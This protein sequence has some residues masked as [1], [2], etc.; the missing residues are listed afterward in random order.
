MP[1]V[2]IFGV[3]WGIGDIVKGGC[4]L[5]KVKFTSYFH[6]DKLLKF[7]YL[8]FVNQAK[9]IKKSTYRTICIYVLC[10]CIKMLKLFK[11]SCYK[12][13]W[14]IFACT[15]CT[16]FIDDLLSTTC[17]LSIHYVKLE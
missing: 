9:G 5:C 12:I 7:V 1:N 2:L 6:E 14:N 15:F 13:K 11:L 10:T 16:V 3:G 4:V 8:R 17:I